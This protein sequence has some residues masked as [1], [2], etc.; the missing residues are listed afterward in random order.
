MKNSEKYH[1][2][3]FTRQNY[4][5]L[6]KIAKKKYNFRNFTN[7]NKNERFIL[8][9]HDVDFSVHSALAL[10]KIEFSESIKSTYFLHIHNIF[11]NLFEKEI[12][13]KVR[14]IIQLGHS[15]GLHFDTHYYSIKRST[16][17]EK[18]LRFEKKILE[19]TFKVKINVFSF[20]NTSPLVLSFNKIEYAGMINTYSRYFKEKIHYCS[21]SNGYWRHERLEDI[22]TVL[23]PK[24]LQ[25]LTH[26][27][28]WQKEPMSPKERI[29]RCIKGRAV[30]TEVKYSQ[31]L[32][33]FNR[34]DIE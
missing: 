9:R 1:F 30:K 2:N 32:K 13:D 22:L 8:W 18:Y 27:A 34:K 33:Q 12:S 10:A 25:V 4:R 23:N 15:I 5:R 6:L 16:D 20:H 19:Q 11:Y 28:W 14:K 24:N 17:L 21:D 26:P 3:D 31:T 29:R 7:F